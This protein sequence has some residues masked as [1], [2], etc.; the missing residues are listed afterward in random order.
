MYH[1]SHG[2]QR[3]H[4]LHGTYVK[5]LLLGGLWGPWLHWAQ[6]MHST[7]SL[8]TTASEKLYQSD[9]TAKAR[10]LKKRGEKVGQG[11]IVAE[12]LS[13]QL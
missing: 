7:Y 8:L 11:H 3:G 4:S 12:L 13:A 1:R 2:G 9:F 6:F 10:L 5:W